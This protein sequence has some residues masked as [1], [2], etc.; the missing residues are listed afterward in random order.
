MRQARW[1]AR[2]KRGHGVWIA[3]LGMNV[4]YQA[5][6]VS[7]ERYATNGMVGQSDTGA[8]VV[9]GRRLIIGVQVEM[10]ASGRRVP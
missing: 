9:V 2:L 10:Q 7:V 4:G 8:P 1:E 5:R 6:R 3:T